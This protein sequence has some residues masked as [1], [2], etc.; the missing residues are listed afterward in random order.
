MNLIMRRRLINNA[1][2]CRPTT[3]KLKINSLKL[4]RARQSRQKMLL[5]FLVLSSLVASKN[6]ERSIWM[7]RRSSHFWDYIVNRTFSERD[8]YENF[9]LSKATFGYL[10][11]KLRP[12]IERKDTQLRRAIGVEL[13]VAVT[14]WCLATSTDYRTLGHLFGISVCL[15]VQEVCRAIVNSLTK[16]YIKL[17]N[18]NELRAMITHFKE[19]FGFPC[20][21]GALDGSHIPI[22]A[23]VE[24][25]TD[26]Y[27]RKG[28]YSIVL[29]GLVDHRY[30][31]T[32][33]YTGW[34]G[35]V[36]D[37][38]VFSQS[39]LYRKG[40]SG[41]LYPNWT[42][43]IAGEDIP[44]VILGDSLLNWLMK[45][46]PHKGALSQGQ[47]KYNYHL[48][49]ARVVSENAF[50]RLKGR[51][52]CL[53]KRIDMAPE[54]VPV[55]IIACCTLHNICELH[56]DEFNSD[57][58]SDDHVTNT[59]TSDDDEDSGARCTSRNTTPSATNIRNALVQ[60]F[61]QL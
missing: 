61:D 34:P 42:V 24:H 21:G 12:I 23:P 59:S 56:G 30:C 52:R 51:W 39:S 13:R 26:Y 38:R 10:C 32:D 55:L 29:Q 40:T 50:G 15:I 31:F 18:G 46:F 4:F 7:K 54:H 8:W 41:T 6:V 35:S 37:A 3:K 27:N 49:T 2:T 9:R 28:W 58:L 17:P 11:Q 33:V 19:N 47:K 5:L 20:C 25:H 48:S 1:I 14:L 45:P 43:S 57:W 36:H 16:D 60:Y 53:L 44:I 22:A